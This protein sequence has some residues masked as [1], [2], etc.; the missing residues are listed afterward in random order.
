VVTALGRIA[1]TYSFIFV[2]ITTV[3]CM[4]GLLLIRDHLSSQ[5]AA[6][7]GHFFSRWDFEAHVSPKRAWV[8]RT[9]K[10]FF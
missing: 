1:S 8:R 3:S 7:Y 5:C 9:G 2:G 10:D 4:H 6:Q